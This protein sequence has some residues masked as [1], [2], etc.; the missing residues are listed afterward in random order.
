[1][2]RGANSIQEWMRPPTSDDF[3]RFSLLSCAV[4]DHV[5]LVLSLLRVFLFQDF[6]DLVRD[7]VSG[8]RRVKAA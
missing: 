4:G 6:Q 5:M 1:M 7:V 8:D 2:P 3:E